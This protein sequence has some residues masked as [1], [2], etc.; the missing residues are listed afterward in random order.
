MSLG[1]ARQGLAIGA[2]LT[3]VGLLVA[4]TAPVMGADAG[5]GARARELIAGLFVVGGWLI[6]AWAIHRLGREG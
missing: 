6:L 4:A 5:A 3:A 2:G 1:T